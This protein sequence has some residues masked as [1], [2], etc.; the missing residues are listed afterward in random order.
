MFKFNLTASTKYEDGFK[1]IVSADSKESEK[2]V[3]ELVRLII[4]KISKI[5][6]EIKSQDVE[7]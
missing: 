6:V 3:A 1:L 2:L 7:Y 4:S 5:T